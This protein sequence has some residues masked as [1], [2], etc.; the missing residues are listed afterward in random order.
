MPLDMVC[1][2]WD[3]DN[4]SA[5]SESW[6]LVPTFSYMVDR[7][8][9]AHASTSRIPISNIHPQTMIVLQL[10]RFK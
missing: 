8:S 10:E 3:Y 7:H 4:L 2:T 9:Y 1:Y 5:P 6:E